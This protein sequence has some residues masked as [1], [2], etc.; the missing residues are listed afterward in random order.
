MVKAIGEIKR[1]RG[2]TTKGSVAAPIPWAP[3]P[4]FRF[5]ARVG[6]DKGRSCHPKRQRG[7]WRR[8]H[9]VDRRADAIGD[10]DPTDYFLRGD[11]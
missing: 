1:R 8:K 5:H 3:E 4:G 2:V 11:S 7:N 10:V 9:R 6:P